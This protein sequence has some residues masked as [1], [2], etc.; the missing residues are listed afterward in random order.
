MPEHHHI[1]IDP[2]PD[3]VD[4]Q[5]TL[6]GHVHHHGAAPHV[7]AR[8]VQILVLSH[9]NQW[10]LQADARVHHPEHGRWEA[11]VVAGFPESTGSF[12]IVAVTGARIVTSPLPGPD[13]PLLPSDAVISDPIIVIR[14]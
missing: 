11:S 3:A 2:V 6:R 9:D 13:L 10:Y 5:F 8:G 14:K 7:R 12:T 1:H 4:H